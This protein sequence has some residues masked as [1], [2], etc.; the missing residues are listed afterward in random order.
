MN[1]ADWEM[2]EAIRKVLIGIQGVRTVRLIRTKE[3]V[4]VPLSRLVAALLEPTETEA[5]TWPEVPVGAYHLLHWRVSVLDRAMPGTRAFESLVSVAEACRDGILASSLLGGQAEDG[6]P[7]ARGGDLAPDVG[8]T[9]I[10]PIRLAEVIAGQPI[11]LVFHGA[12]GYWAESMTGAAT[13]DDEMLFSS[14]PHIV[15]VGSPVRRVKDQLFNGLVGGLV[16]DLGDGPRPIEQKGILSA[17]T[18]TGLALLEAA[19][20]SFIDGHAY[21]LTTP[22]GTD[23]PNCRLER[24]ERLGPP[25][26]GTRWHQT[27]RAIYQQLAR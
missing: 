10:G 2:L 25:Q 15:T 24:F 20:E 12:S 7:S 27:Y 21:T 1:A 3:S 11:A 19:I 13:L 8:A 17:S 14:G 18:A 9:R 22:N 4:E 23:Y 16:L 26:A 6:P 5:G